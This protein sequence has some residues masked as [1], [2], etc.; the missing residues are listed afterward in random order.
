MFPPSHAGLLGALTS[1]VSGRYRVERE[2]GAGGMATVY[3]AHDVKHDRDVAIKVLHPDLGVALGAERFLSEIRTTAR[4]QHPHVLPLLDSGEADGLLFYVMPYV[5]GETLRARLAREGQLPI[6]EAVRVAREVASALDHAHRHGVIHRDVKPEN[7]LLADG[8]ALVADFGIALA[9]QQAGGRRMTQTGLSLGTPQYMSPEQAMGEKAID[10]R[11]DVYALGCVLY[12]MLAGEPPFTGASVQ[13]IVARL[14][15]EEPRPLVVERRSI[16]EHVEAV[17]LRALEK[18]PADRF[19]TAADFAAALDGSAAITATRTGRSRAAARP[20]RRATLALGAV[21][22]VSAGLAAW[23]WLRPGPRPE[24]VR[25]T[26]VV[27]SVPAVKDWSGEVAISTDGATIVRAG[28]PKGALLVRRRDELAFSPLAGTE[29]ASGPFFSPDGARVGYYANGAYVAV[30]LAGGPAVVIADSVPM[31]VAASWGSDGYLYRTL[32]TEGAEVVVRSEAR[33]GAPVERLTTVDTAAG[34]LTHGAPEVLP[35]GET[36]VFRVAYRDGRRMIAVAEVGTGRHTPLM[37]GARA[38]YARGGRL[39]Y[40]TSDGK[41]WSVPFDAGRRAT[42]GTAVQVADRIPASV[43]G[44]VDF[45][46]SA[47]GTLVYSVDDVGPRRELTWV[48]RTGARVPLDAG[49]KGEFS[50]PVLSPDG[51]RVAV[52]IRE[53]AQSHVWIKSVAGG[54]PTKLTVEHRGN[55][56]PA[57]SPDGGWV[58][59]LAS[60]GSANTGDVWRQRAD[61]SGR[62]E[63]AVRSP[64]P[65]SEQVWAP[66][67]DAFVVRTTTPTAGAGDIL[68]ARPGRDIVPAPV[69]AS[70]RNEYSPAL[71]PDGR[72]LA[73]AGGETGRIEVY[74]VPF[75]APGTAKWV[76][77][78]SGGSAPRWSPRGDELFYLD[79]RSNLVAARVATAPSFAV[80]GTRVLFNASDFIHTSLSRRNYDV[81]ADGQRFLM[82]Q[83]ADGAKRGQVVVV[84]HWLEEVRRTARAP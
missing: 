26:I 78:T 21:A 15:S 49:W 82:V 79:A 8:Q 76:V 53:G 35:D 65:L 45:A 23:G 25:Y 51:S 52:T 22:A 47:S 2:L 5:A 29:G 14:I 39:L 55:V 71:S 43:V 36:L 40:T 56:E 46:V 83:R 80:Q 13:A 18:L 16:P 75:D 10:A 58:S 31:P 28:G 63:R 38:R 33:A 12:E 3:L 64:R 19:A 62:A 27:D 41:L 84:E 66:V 6:P 50:S 34:E 37:Q 70:A 1:A 74:V 42:S 60:A 69:V 4:L 11:S 48:T 30:P 20:A 67:G 44:P 77:S 32:L 68:V 57:W 24:V 73:Y 61:G 54:S 81:A 72:W 59:Y 17:V 7:I 9:V